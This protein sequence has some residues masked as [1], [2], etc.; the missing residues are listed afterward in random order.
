MGRDSYKAEILS[1][2]HHAQHSRPLLVPTQMTGRWM[3]PGFYL[4]LCTVIVTGIAQ[5]KNTGLKEL[6]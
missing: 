6:R 1:L 3:L 5:T 2:H 4:Y